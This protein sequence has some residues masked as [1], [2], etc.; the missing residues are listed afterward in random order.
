MGQMYKVGSHA[1]SIEEIDG[2]T[3]ITYHET[4]VVRFNENSIVLDSGGWLTHTT[5]A[6]MNQA[7]REFEL[8]YMVYQSSFKWYV[9]H[10]GKSVVFFDGIELFRQD[11]EYLSPGP[12]LFKSKITIGLGRFKMTLK[13]DGIKG[14]TY[15]K[16]VFKGNIL[17]T[18]HIFI[19]PTYR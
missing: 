9:E 14:E 2:V 12:Q 8:D 11:G 1:T 6:R 13:V 3:T 15:S 10:K 16:I 18:I 4:P 5:K 17:S 19:K 7:S